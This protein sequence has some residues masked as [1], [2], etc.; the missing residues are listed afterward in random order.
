MYVSYEKEVFYIFIR[1]FKCIGCGKFHNGLPNIWISFKN[2][3]AETI[4]NITEEELCPLM[5]FVA[6][7]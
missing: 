4:E 2:Y 6:I 7:Q 5:P 1:R 3:S